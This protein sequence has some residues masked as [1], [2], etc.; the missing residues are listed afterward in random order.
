MG[1]TVLWEMT[2]FGFAFSWRVDTLNSYD[3]YTV[4]YPVRLLSILRPFSSSQTHTHT[5]KDNSQATADFN[6][7]RM[8][9]PVDCPAVS[10]MDH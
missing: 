3:N 4:K 5:H 9:W 8:L 1:P 7:N 6:V 2:L 10:V